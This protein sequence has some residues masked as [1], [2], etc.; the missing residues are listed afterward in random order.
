MQAKNFDQKVL[1]S[2]YQLNVCLNSKGD[3]SVLVLNNLLND[4]ECSK[5]NS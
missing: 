3:K 5:P 1:Q 2:T 4:C